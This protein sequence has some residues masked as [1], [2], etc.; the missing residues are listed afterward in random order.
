MKMSAKEVINMITE[1]YGD[2]E[3]DI[4]EVKSIMSFPNGNVAVFDTKGKQV[5]FIQGLLSGAEENIHA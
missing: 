5:A 3:K 1:Q 2:T 4:I